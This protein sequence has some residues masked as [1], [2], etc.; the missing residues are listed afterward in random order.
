MLTRSEDAMGL[1]F[2]D[3]HKGKNSDGHVIERDDG[4]VDVDTLRSYF[5]EYEDWSSEEKSAMR[6]CRGRVL[7][8]GCGVGKHSIH[9]QGKG[10]DVLGIDNSPLALKVCRERGLKRT[11][12]MSADEV[13]G[14]LGK[15]DTV[16][17]MGNNFGL[18]E[19]PEKAR[20]MLATFHRAT[21]PGARIIAQTMDPYATEKKGHL[22]YQARN[23]RLGRMPG[24]IRLRIRYDRLATPWFDYLIVSREEM[25]EI[26]RGTGWKVSRFI[27]KGALYIA[28]IVKT[29]R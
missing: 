19:N 11:K 17:M 14:K 16:I 25:K 15:F 6:L 20:E 2:W 12:C 4:F 23:R 24:Q 10:L 27:G 13:E 21:S 28:V 1:S 3:C 9:L 5:Q 18:F 7:D 26:L 8:V 29:G 22:E